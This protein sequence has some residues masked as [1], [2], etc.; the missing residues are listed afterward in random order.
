MRAALTLVSLCVVY[1]H[2]AFRE[3]FP[4]I[5]VLYCKIVIVQAYALVRMSV[6]GCMKDDRSANTGM[7]AMRGV[8][9]PQ[10]KGLPRR[11]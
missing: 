1:V 5:Q 2:I 9:L 4:V 8:R 7:R 3:C 11:A 10:L 6:C